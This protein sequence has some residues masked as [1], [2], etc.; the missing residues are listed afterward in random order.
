MR[1]GSRWILAAW[2][3]A[4]V[5]AAAQPPA[6]ATRRDFDWCSEVVVRPDQRRK[7]VGSGCVI[8]WP[9]DAIAA[10]AGVVLLGDGVDTS[11]PVF[12]HPVGPCGTPNSHAD[13]AR[14]IA[15]LRALRAKRGGAPLLFVHMHRFDLVADTLAALPGFR[16]DFLLSTDRPW[17]DV[18]S[19]F[20][21]DRS[22]QCGKQGCRWSDA[23]G[24][25]EDR[26]RGTWLRDWIEKSGGPRRHESVVYY[27]V[28]ASQ[29]DRLFWPT[30]AIADLRNPAYRAWRVAE[31]K[32][33][34]AIGG[35]DAILLNHKFHQ[36]QGEPHWIG[37]PKAPD[38]AALRKNGDD[39]LWTA[40][41]RGYGYP[42]YVEGYAAL[43]A[44]LRAAG[45][46]YQ[47]E[48]RT[49]PWLVREADDPST[50][51]RDEER[52][53]RDVAR[54][55]R[56]ALLD[57]GRRVDYVRFLEFADELRRA[58]VHVVI[59]RSECGFGRP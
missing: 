35:Y 33:A 21:K 46:P 27:L 3:V 24:G 23:F 41:P 45:V 51:D 25:W 59:A 43:A 14:Y 19:F 29:V 39:T 12:L 13:N 26:G 32:R 38:V 47:F 56:I 49:W 52:M 15:R 31:A 11:E 58:G 44:D 57:P 18:T 9:D 42:E 1:R 17:S 6:P 22:P 8:D 16:A 53:I 4:A 7:S 55:A 5:P 30:A 10:G 40:P 48:M 2:L 54:G 20:A 50:P 36:Y 37:G 34:V 28:R